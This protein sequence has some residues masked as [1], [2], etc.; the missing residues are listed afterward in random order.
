[1]LSMVAYS[2]DRRVCGRS[3]YVEFIYCNEYFGI[4][5]KKDRKVALDPR[6]LLSECG[7]NQ[8]QKGQLSP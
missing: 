5:V 2:V 7:V 3:C 4:E 8:T 6:Y 1:M